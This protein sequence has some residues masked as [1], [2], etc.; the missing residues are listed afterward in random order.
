VLRSVLNFSKSENMM[1][2]TNHVIVVGVECLTGGSFVSNDVSSIER[3][4]KVTEH[5]DLQNVSF[6]TGALALSKR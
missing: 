3:L 2:M 6:V 1:C 5:A 4:Q